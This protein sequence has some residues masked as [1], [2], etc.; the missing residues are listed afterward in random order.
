M[1]G[2]LPPGSAPRRDGKPEPVQSGWFALAGDLETGT[3]SGFTEWDKGFD[4]Y[5]PQTLEAPDGRVLLVGWM[6]M[7]D[8]DYR[9]PTAALGCSTV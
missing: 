2:R 5:A 9:N 3:I 8:A 1:A 7:P 4:F 6:G